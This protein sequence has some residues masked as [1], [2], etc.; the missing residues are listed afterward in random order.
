MLPAKAIQQG[1][2]GNTHVSRALDGK[3]RFLNPTSKNG[4]PGFKDLPRLEQF[5]I[6]RCFKPPNCS[7]MQRYELHHFSDAS[8]QGHCFIPSPGRCKVQY[9]LIMAKSRLLLLKAMTIPRMELSAAV[10]AARLHRIIQQE[11]GMTVHSSTF[12]TDGTCVL[13]Y[14]EN[15]DRS[16][17]VFVANRVSAILDRSTAT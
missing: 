1:P 14:I 6:P 13:R 17:Q 2:M 3:I 10:L 5:E 4:K 12:W 15:N 16:C 11:I 7:E 9:S 8:S